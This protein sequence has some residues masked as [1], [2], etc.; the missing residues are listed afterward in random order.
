MKT[1]TD[2]GKKMKDVTRWECW[3]DAKARIKAK[4][5]KKKQKADCRWQRTG[6]QED[7]SADTL[8]DCGGIQMLCDGIQ[9]LPLLPRTDEEE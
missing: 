8:T 5:A 1:T 9:P 7:T 4:Q 3:E 2:G 6:S